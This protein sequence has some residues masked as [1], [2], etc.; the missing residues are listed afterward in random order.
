MKC[1]FL[2]ITFALNALFAL[3]FIH[4][5]VA[6]DN[7]TATCNSGMAAVD[8]PNETNTIG[9]L[10]DGAISF[11]LNDTELISG[12]IY[13]FPAAQNLIWSIQALQIAFTG[14]LVRFEADESIPFFSVPY[15]TILE[16]DVDRLDFSGIQESEVCAALPGNIEGATHTTGDNKLFA[17]GTVNFGLP[18][19]ITID[20]T[21][22]FTDENSTQVLYAYD[23][24]T[25]SIEE[26]ISE[27][28][29]VAP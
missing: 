21:V 17:N 11:K 10:S 13:T 2:P 26:V 15:A 7:G 23:Q 22:I 20:V 29:S 4:S 3:D 5:V 19:S 12:G 8:D 25:I 14:F 1:I 6:L 24:F 27:I 9:S 18:G 16:D 28:P